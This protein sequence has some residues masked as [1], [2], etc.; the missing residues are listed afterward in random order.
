MSSPLPIS[1]CLIAGAEAHRIGRVL[2]S[3]EG[4]C[5]EVVVVLNED[6]TDGTEELVIARGGRVYREPWKGF[7]GQKNSVAE[8]ATQEWILNLDADE[9]VSPELRREIEGVVNGGCADAAYEF[10]RC[11]LYCGRWIRHGDWY[12]D[13][14]TRLWRR[15]KAHWAGEDPHARLEV[16]GTMGR[17]RGDLWHYSFESIEHQISKIAPYQRDVV[18][19]RM[20][21]GRPA[22]LL[23][24]VIRP[25]WRFLRGYIFRLGF[26][27]GW[28][29]YYIARLNAFS[30]LTRYAMLREAWGQQRGRGSGRSG[31]GGVG[32]SR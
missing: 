2:A 10:P 1:V 14:V 6:V 30:T 19:R 4:W 3:V 13:R 29:G 20:A 5:A 11:T 9:E 7:I 17:L 18:Q 31:D 22:L 23:E 12:P 8:K 25:W 15:G 27:D 28:Q 24:L 21:A 16:D 32:R 26:L